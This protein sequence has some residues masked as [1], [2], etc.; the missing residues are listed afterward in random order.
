MGLPQAPEVCCHTPNALDVLGE[1][2]R[3]PRG[4]SAGPPSS[5]GNGSQGSCSSASHAQPA[6]LQITYC[7]DPKIT[8]TVS[9]TSWGLGDAQLLSSG[10]LNLGLFLDKDYKYHVKAS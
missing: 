6:G 1:D 4:S 8:G 3:V 7:G 10:K 5:Q 2:R 9:H